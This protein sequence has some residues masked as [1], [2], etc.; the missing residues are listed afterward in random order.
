MNQVRHGA[1]KGVPDRNAAR[2]LVSRILSSGCVSF[3]G[4]AKVEM[5]NDRLSAVDVENV[6]RGG[7]ILR[8]PEQH[9]GEWRYRVETNAVALVVALDE[10]RAEVR[11][12]TAWRKRR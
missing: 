12:I 9:D 11:V 8:A 2:R 10:T 7:R 6:L 1:G 3:T 4:H 5:A